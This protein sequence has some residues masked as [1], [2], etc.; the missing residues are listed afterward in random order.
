[1][2]VWVVFLI[3]GAACLLIGLVVSANKKQAAGP[4]KPGVTLQPYNPGALDMPSNMPSNISLPTQWDELAITRQL[5]QLRDR[6][7]NLIPHYI[8]SVKERWIVRQDDRTG[9]VRL[10]FLKIQIE[11]LKLTKEFQQ[12]VDDL[13]LLSLEKTKR[14]KTIELET[15][16][17]DIKKRGLTQKEKLEALREQKKLELEIAQLDKQINEI[18]KPSMAAEPELTAEEKRVRERQSC[19][20]R[21]ANYKAEKQKALQV[22]DADE[23][24]LRVN[25][26]DDAIQREMERWARLL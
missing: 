2:E 15:E 4:Q 5:Q 7:P 20:E 19:E 8:D 17:I 9:Q 13:E 24:V 1:M 6:K 23:R 21:L 18:K 16:E 3:L 12:T 26:I 10:Q 11:Q 25:A 14:I 22:D